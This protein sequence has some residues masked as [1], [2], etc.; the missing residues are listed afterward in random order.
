L[1]IS[2]LI[3]RTKLTIETVSNSL[4]V[5]LS[6][7]F[8]LEGRWE[9]TSSQDQ[10]SCK[11]S[12]YFC[13]HFLKRTYLLKG[14]IESDSLSLTKDSFIQWIALAKKKLKDDALTLKS[15]ADSLD[16]SSSSKKLIDSSSTPSTSATILNN[17]NSNLQLNELQ[18]S[19][20]QLISKKRFKLP[21]N[22][23]IWGLCG[24]S[25]LVSLYSPLLGNLLLALVIA[26]VFSEVKKQ[27]ED[28]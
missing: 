17:N 4:G 14:R 13:V 20:Q 28:S 10:K 15:V 22:Q 24:V 26:F 9:V 27:E 7:S 3:L 1:Y 5:P 6:D 19:M 23:F 12:I 11:L 21:S 8:Q 25:V 2:L 18:T 16:L